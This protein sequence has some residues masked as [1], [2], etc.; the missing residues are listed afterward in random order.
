MHARQHAERAGKTDRLGHTEAMRR[1]AAA[2]GASSATVQSM[3]WIVPAG[4]PDRACIDQPCLSAPSSNSAS[5]PHLRRCA[6]DPHIWQV[7]DCSSEATKRPTASSPRS[8]LPIPST[9][10][11]D[12]M[13]TTSSFRKCVAHEMQGSWLRTA[14][15][16]RTRSASSGIS[17]QS[18][19]N[20]SDH[21]RC[22]AGSAMSAARSWP[23]RSAIGIQP[24]AMVQ[25]AA[26]RFSAGVAH[27]GTRRQ[28]QMRLVRL[29]VCIDDPQRLVAG[30]QHL[31]R[32]HHDAAERIVAG[33]AKPRLL[34]RIARQ[35]RQLR[36]SSGCSVRSDRSGTAV[37]A[38]ASAA[39][40]SASHA[41]P[42][43]ARHTAAARCPG[44]CSRPH[45]RH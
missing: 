13:R 3:R 26:R 15:S 24:V 5:S 37:P 31:H 27:A 11:A 35:R 9:T 28:V 32:A 8:G 18:P 44:P 12:H 7:P 6:R 30:V 16:Q 38:D 39:R 40:W 34:R 45:G 2:G 29:L 20:A 41:I 36:R 14:C 17:S 43:S 33:R 1:D 23:P 10:R 21:P 42:R 25:H 4:A 19:A 22:S